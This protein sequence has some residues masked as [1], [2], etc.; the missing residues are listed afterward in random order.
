MAAA[1]RYNSLMA[2]TRVKICGIKDPATAL[3]AVYAG[4]DAVG[5]VFVSASRRCVTID[6]AREI[7]DVLPPFVEPIGLFVD[8][9]PERVGQVA[10]TLD[11]RTVQLHGN[12]SSEYA[13]HLAPLR[14]IK[15]V[16]LPDDLSQ[17]AQ[18]VQP[19]RSS[20]HDNLTALLWDALPPRGAVAALTG[21][22]GRTFDWDALAKAQKHEPF[23]DL[24]PT[25][26]A[27]GLTPANVGQAIATL[28][29]FAVDVSSG[30]ESSPG[31]KDVTM[32]RDFCRAVR[33]ADAGSD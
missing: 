1:D 23:E 10:E 8:A 7:I 4:T 5:L 24:P 3:A 20:H 28:R 19:W 25:I 12:E 18:L 16:S 6:Q 26:L 32:I 2:R 17:A 33:E 30:V 22:T 13:D 9:A 11:L 27:G 21:G 31:V 15:A 29:P 14:V